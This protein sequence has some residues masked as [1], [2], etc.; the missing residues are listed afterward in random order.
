VALFDEE[1]EAVAGDGSFASFFSLLEGPFLYTPHDAVVPG[2]LAES[3]VS[4][5]I[6]AL[7]PR[8]VRLEQF[9]NGLNRRVA[10]PDAAR[11]LDLAV[12]RYR[13]QGGA[14]NL[15]LPAADPG[16][17]VEESTTE[18]WLLGSLKR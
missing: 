11:A 9:V 13:A 8:P 17:T 3:D 7:A 15:C 16:S 4:D 12:R 10:S 1:V 2:V 14:T 18:K 5:L 6:A